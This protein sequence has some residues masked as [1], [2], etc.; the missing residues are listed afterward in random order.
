MTYLAP[1]RT[2]AAVDDG[3]AA[4]DLTHELATRPARAPDH[5]AENQAMGALALELAR[6][7]AQVPARVEDGL[8]ALCR[9]AVAGTRLPEQDGAGGRAPGSGPVLLRDPA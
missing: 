2:V 1:A 3:V 4:L 8:R 5:A 7:P 6:D 9:C